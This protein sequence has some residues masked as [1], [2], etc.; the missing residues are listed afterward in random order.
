MAGAAN[1]RG[2]TRGRVKQPHPTH[3]ATVPG[4]RLV[5]ASG[6]IKY[7][8]IEYR[9]GHDRRQVGVFDNPVVAGQMRLA[10]R[11]MIPRGS[12]TYY[13]VEKIKRG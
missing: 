12:S 11:K 7:R 13:V 4:G 9:E 3:A 10:L 5:L 1:R 8:L 6:R 2:R